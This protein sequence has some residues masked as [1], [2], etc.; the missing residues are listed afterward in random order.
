MLCGRENGK[1]KPPEPRIQAASTGAARIELA[2][3][4]VD[5][6]IK[7]TPDYVLPEPDLRLST[8]PALQAVFIRL[9]CAPSP[10]LRHYPERL[11]TM[12]APSPCA[13]AFRR[14]PGYA[15]PS[16]RV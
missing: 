7:G 9:P 4:R 3:G 12:S 6:I 2:T 15:K 5:Q 8:H 11:S 10:C 16:V 13:F 14:S 1:K